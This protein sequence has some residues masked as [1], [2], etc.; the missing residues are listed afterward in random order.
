M[1]A[2]L[3]TLC[4]F[5]LSTAIAR[6]CIAR[7]QVQIAIKEG[8]EYVSHGAT[9][10][11]WCCCCLPACTNDFSQ[12]YREKWFLREFCFLQGNDQVRFEMTYYALYPEVKVG[13]AYL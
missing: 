2:L 1:Y 3:Y 9:G 4:E 5:G 10:K 13:T 11:V 6:P 7:R 8:A 12:Y